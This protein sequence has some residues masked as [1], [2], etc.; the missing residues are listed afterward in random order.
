MSLE[1][2]TAPSTHAASTKT[3]I[4]PQHV[5]LDERDPAEYSR[6]VEQQNVC[7]AIEASARRRVS[8]SSGKNDTARTHETGQRDQ[9]HQSHSQSPS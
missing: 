4:G 8:A 7:G 3:I 6:C 9:D 1:N 5:L 2:K